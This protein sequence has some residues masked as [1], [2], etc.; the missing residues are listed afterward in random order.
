MNQPNPYG[1]QQYPPQPP[2]PPAPPEPS[3]Q[4]ARNGLG[5][6]GFV[7]GLIGLIFSVIPIIGVVAWP[8]VILGFIFSLIGLNRALKKK[9]TNKG[10]A[11]AGIVL[12]VIG[13][14][15]CIVWTAAFGKAANDLNNQINST[16]AVHYE[17]T[18]TAKNPTI[19]YS[20]F[21]DGASTTNQETTGT[22]PWSK[23]V[24]TKGLIKGGSLTVTTGADGGSVTCKV[25][26]DGKAAKTAT[27]SG[28]FASAN[29]DGF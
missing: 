7:L 4:A 12:S 24:T 25:T 20:T 13:L 8:L 27:A 10:L 2:Y 14:V 16:A 23:D 26:V 6:A 1:Q 5:T 11:I 19:T 9:A 22:L 15:I 21:G 17:V 29:C 28:Q 3:V 18:G